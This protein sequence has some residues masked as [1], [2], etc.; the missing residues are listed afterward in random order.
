M[1]FGYTRDMNLKLKIVISVLVLVAGVVSGYQW[2][3]NKPASH[4]FVGNVVEVVKDSGQIKISGVYILDATDKPQDA[5]TEEVVVDYDSSTKF[6]KTVMYRPSDE[7]LKKSNG[8]WDMSKIKTDTVAGSID[9]LSINRMVTV[10]THSNI[11]GA[12]K[13]SASEVSYFMIGN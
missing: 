11:L 10:K 4:K 6:I 2:Y 8:V 7:E 3:K 5:K 12:S 13:I 9:D 1:D